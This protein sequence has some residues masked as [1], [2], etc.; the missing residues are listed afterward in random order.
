MCLQTEVGAWVVRVNVT[1]DS[2]FSSE[3]QNFVDP[4]IYRGK[5]F[6][7]PDPVGISHQPRRDRM[8][9]LQNVIGNIPMLFVFGWLR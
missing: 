5:S 2:L 3:L 9:G 7:M 1:A 6:K 4:L 8:K